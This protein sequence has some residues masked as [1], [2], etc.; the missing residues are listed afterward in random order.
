MSDYINT[1]FDQPQTF[2]F[3]FVVLHIF[4]RIVLWG[5][6]S[7]HRAECLHTELQIKK[8]TSYMYGNDLLWG[9]FLLYECN[10]QRELAFRSHLYEVTGI[11]HAIFKRMHV[12]GKSVL[13]QSFMASAKLEGLFSCGTFH[14]KR[15]TWS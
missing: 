15:I 8:H 5:A 10:L 11:V 3:S 13:S 6:Q 12:L 9:A 2:A 4:S 7:Y 14:C 1:L